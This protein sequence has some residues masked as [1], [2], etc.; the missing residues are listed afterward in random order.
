MIQPPS[1]PAP[2][3]PQYQAQ[4]YQQP[5]YQ[6]SPYQTPQYQQPQ[7]QP[8]QQ[9]QPQST[10]SLAIAGMVL[11]IIAL[12]TSL[13]PII[14]NFSFFI[15]LI[16]VVLAIIGMVGI[17]KGKAKGKGFAITGIV[18]N[19]IAII[20]VLASQA[21]YGAVLDAASESLK[22]PSAVSQS[23]SSRTA[24]TSS[25]SMTASSSSSS[26]STSAAADYTVTIDGMQLGKD[27]QG[28]Q[29]AIIT[30]TFTNNSPRDVSF[31]G[32]IDA[33]A[34]QNGV[35]LSTAIT[36]EIDAS[37]SLNQIKTGATTTVQQAY[38]LTD[39]SPVTVEVSE[40]MDFSDT[41]IAEKTFNVA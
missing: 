22:T 15:A 38:T 25:S 9:P 40:L 36:T 7:Y 16:G 39:T 34:F 37:K 1:Y 8:P 32:T 13:I 4:Q 18:L 23:S 24:S 33:E 3:Q 28:K 35:E 14:N 29:I 12:I 10:S 21:F 27:Y 26:S 20:A 6:A 2:Q 17:A 30:Y 41:V 5:Q 19:V 31:T 11:G